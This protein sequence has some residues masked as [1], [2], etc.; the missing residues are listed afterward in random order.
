MDANGRQPRE[1]SRDRR[2]RETRESLL[3][4]AYDLFCTLGYAGTSLDEVADRAGFTKGAI[5]AHFDGKEGLFLTLIERTTTSLVSQWMEPDPG[6]TADGQPEADGI[7]EWLSQ[8]MHERRD[9]FLVTA[10]FA[11]LAA[12]KPALAARQL[13]AV[14]RVCD[15]IASWLTR[16]GV[17]AT[18]T[19]ISSMSRLLLAMMNGLVLHTALDE[20]IDTAADLRLGMKLFT[21]IPRT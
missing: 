2:R 17:D 1:N 8:A 21:G 20:T 4:A 16:I 3:N 11:L 14:D 9:W 15:D 19:E 13:A 6:R 5:Y 10:E 12:R 7:G 18:T